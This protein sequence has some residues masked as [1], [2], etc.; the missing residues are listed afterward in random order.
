MYSQLAH[1]VNRQALSERE[2]GA[3]GV[4]QPVYHSKITLVDYQLVP[5]RG[6]HHRHRRVKNKKNSFK[7]TLV[8]QRLISAR[9]RKR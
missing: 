4:N 9:K 5:R 8:S 2:D 3:I 1:E 7:V 6:D